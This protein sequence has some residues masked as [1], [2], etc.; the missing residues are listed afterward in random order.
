[1]TYWF[2]GEAISQSLQSWKQPNFAHHH[3]ICCSCAVRKIVPLSWVIFND[4]V[5][6]K[7]DDLKHNAKSHVNINL[8]LLKQIQNV[9]ILIRI[10]ALQFLEE[11][12][13]HEIFKL[14]DRYLKN[15]N[16]FRKISQF[17]SY[18]ETKYIFVISMIVL[19]PK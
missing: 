17:R 4:V 18:L 15:L 8:F 6:G 3:K 13:F 16:I 10:V 7:I 14:A 2:Q 5:P 9:F 1:M 12:A 19:F 11:I